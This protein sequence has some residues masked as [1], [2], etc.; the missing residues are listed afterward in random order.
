MMEQ[1]GLKVISL[2]DEGADG[3]TIPLA[4]IDPF[5]FLATFNRG[6]TDKNRRDNW[7]FLKSR[8]KLKA[9][10]P[11]DFTGIPILHN[12]TSRLFPYAKDREK[13]HVGLLWQLAALAADG[14]VEKVDAALF[15]RCAKLETVGIR[16]LTIC[17]FWI[18]P[19]KFLSADSKNTAYGKSKGI[20]TEPE[21]FQSYRQ[22]LIEMT[23]KVGSNYPQVSHEAH[24]FATHNQSKLELTPARMQ[25]LWDRFQKVITGFTDFQDPGQYFVENETAFKRAILNRFQQEVGAERL[26]ALVAQGQGTKAAKEIARVLT[27][28]LV[29]FHAWNVTLGESDQAICD[30]VRECLKATSGPYQGPESTSDVFDACARHNLTPSWDALTVLLWALRPQDFFPVKISFYRKLS[31]EL[32][33]ELPSGRPDADKLHSL[34]E[35]GRAFWKALE[36][37]K[38]TDWVDVQSFIWCVCPGNYGKLD[39]QSDT[40]SDGWPFAKWMLPVIDA[41][42]ALGGA[43]SPKAVLAKIQELVS[44]PKEILEAKLASGQSRF[45]NSV[46]WARQY[47]AWEGLI[48]SPKRGVWA[49]TDKGRDMR[50]DDRQAQKIAERWAERH[51][52]QAHSGGDT[53]PQSEDEPATADEGLQETPGDAESRQYWTLSAGTGGEHWGEFYEKGIAAIGWDGTP[54]LRQFKSKD[55]IRQKLLELWPGDSSKKNDAHACWQFVQDI[56]VGD[57]IF[58]KQGVAKLLGYGV[59]EG[60]YQYDLARAH[61]RHVRKVKWISKGE[62]EMPGESKMAL[63]TLTDITPYPGFVRKIASTVRLELDAEP[64]PVLVVPSPSTGVAYWWLNA[65]PKIWNFD[66]TLVG[67]KQTYTSHNEKGNKR[68][69]YRY[70]QEAK[71]GDLV[72]GYVTSPQKEVVAVCKITKGLH[73]TETGEEIEFEKVEQLVKPIAYETLQANPD[74]AN[75]EPLINNQGSLFKLTEQEFE[76]IRSLIDETNI[77]V[78]ITIESYDK[79]K[80]MRGLFLAEAQFDEMLAALREKKNV[81]LQGAP[82]VGKTYVARRLAYALI[83]SNDPQ[84]IEIIQFHQSYSYE[85]FIQGFRPTP[86][87]HFDLKYGIFHQFC[88]R[89][90]RDEGQPY[91]FIIDEINRGNLSKIFGE[92]MMLIE[93]D[94]RG[95]E[96][97]IP[98]AYS[99]DADE[100]FYIPENLHLIGMMNTADRSLAM[101]DY[102]LRRRFRFITL[103]PEFS[104]EAFRASLVDAGAKSELVKKIMA[105]MNALN[106]VIAA[107]TK[108]LGPGY[109]IGHSYFC[110]RNGIKPDDDW[111][112]RVIESEIVPLI[113]EYWFDNEQKVKEQRSALLA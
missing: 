98:L 1:Q 46:H 99:Q 111:Y 85:D 48:E 64:T 26:S 9:A 102:A 49:L 80:A 81:V 33:H 103:R 21:D 89:A 75:S 65:N 79:K 45:Y 87:G 63:K 37:Q 96:H 31:A 41:L 68:Q 55:E 18:N 22:W 106:E 112:R 76:I 61:Y 109:Q 72:I 3:Q 53:V 51:R 34:I 56:K 59:V 77:A 88:R 24:L 4:E 43:G 39:A 36:P 14:G 90:Q 30:V 70:F 42:R 25:T 20:T 69:K 95:K 38:P 6:V 52:R 13:D 44:V 50:L 91:V 2:Q 15:D 74:L 28:N 19:E 62:W 12:M 73:Q 16:R 71:P 40:Q 54:D 105:R 66:E 10:V 60:D 84:R 17:L 57:I 27:S 47:L 101:V 8:W 104:S 83:E 110:P 86:K 58:A 82:G 7:A 97:A 5:S 29:S 78:P 94:K 113:Q 67:E 93:P 108:N 35:F 92:L 107:D 100:T 11:D 23:G 32:D